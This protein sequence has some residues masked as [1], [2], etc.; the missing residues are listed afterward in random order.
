MPPS[1]LIFAHRLERDAA[2]G[3]CDMRNFDNAARRGFVRR[4]DEN[5][6]ALAL[7]AAAS[8]CRAAAA[9][10]IKASSRFP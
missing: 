5:S 2:E 8:G 4:S 10:S 6:F 1:S 3:V 7:S 9:F